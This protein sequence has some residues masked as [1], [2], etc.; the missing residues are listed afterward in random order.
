DEQCRQLDE[1]VW[2][3]KDFCVLI[4]AGNDGTDE[5]GDGKINLMSVTS[6]GTA[7]NC[8]TIGACENKRPE[9]N[10]DVYGRWWPKDYPV[11]PIKD[12]PMADNPDQVV[13][14]SSRGPTRDKRYKPDVVAPGTFILSTRSSMIAL[15]N[16]GWAA[17][18]SSRQ[19]FYMGGTSMATPLSAGSVALIREFLRTKKKITDPS[20][21]LLKAVLIAGATR[22]PGDEPAGVLVD[23]HQGYGRINIDAVVASKANVEFVEVQ[24]GLKTG[25]VYTKQIKVSN[26]SPLRIVLAYSDFPG[27]SLINNLNLILTSP[28]GIKYIGNQPAGGAMMMDT[29]NN[30][31]VIQIDNPTLGIWRMDVIASNIPQG[32]QDFALVY[33]TFS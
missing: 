32:P 20:A 2:N 17:F 19:Y 1:F 11:A 3:N 12:D 5:D 33:V 28:D 6:P 7:K 4:A 30:V 26:N 13:A 25:G 21:A 24:P 10:S 27:S 22:L 31:E 9:F 14:F 15:N 8:I 16:K 23:N 29:V 18:P